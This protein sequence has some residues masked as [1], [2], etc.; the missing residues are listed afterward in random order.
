MAKLLSG[1]YSNP[2]LRKLYRATKTIA[3]QADVGTKVM[4]PCG[5]LQEF[6]KMSKEHVFQK[7]EKN[8]HK[9][10]YYNRT[11][12][13]ANNAFD[14]NML[15]IHRVM[16]SYVEKNKA[17]LPKRKSVKK[18]EPEKIDLR[19][20][21]SEPTFKNL[22]KVMEQN[23]SINKNAKVGEMILCACGCGEKIIKSS[24]QQAFSQSEGKAHKDDY[25]NIVR[26]ENM[27]MTLERIVAFKK[28]HSHVTKEIE[29]LKVQPKKKTSNKKKKI[30]RTRLY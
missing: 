5:C 2:T 3:K 4:C 7:D 8:S 12:S 29:K 20:V 24:Y 19:G 27:D 1:S 21:S 22:K 16:K 15:K 10:Q 23:K 13:T 25:H 30:V 11:R 6:K 17:L 14:S 18:T 28:M 26:T 9:T